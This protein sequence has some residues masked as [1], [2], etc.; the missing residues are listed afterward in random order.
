M[1][2]QKEGQ[3]KEVIQGE[4]NPQYFK[5]KKNKN[6]KI[7]K[8]HFLR[9]ETQVLQEVPDQKKKETHQEQE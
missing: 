5:S 2:L 8:E 1:I 9:K 6:N 4:V 3:G 7:F